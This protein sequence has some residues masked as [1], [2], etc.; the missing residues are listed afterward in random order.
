[1]NAMK[2]PIIGILAN[3]HHY[4][5]GPLPYVDLC[6]LQRDYLYAIERAGGVPMMLPVVEDAATVRQQIAIVD[7]VVLSGGFDVNPAHYGEE[8][9]ALLEEIHP[10]RDAYE[11]MAI[12]I[13]Q[14]LGKPLLGICRGLQILNVAFGG[15]LY[16]DISHAPGERVKHRQKA[17]RFEPTH[18]VDV[19]EGT[20]LRKIVNTSSLATNSFH[21]QAIKQLAPGFVVNAQAKDGVIEG[22]E[23]PGNKFVLAV[24]WHPEMM[25]STDPYAKA[26]FSEF[27]NFVREANDKA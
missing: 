21:H 18:S 27:V 19:M 5:S 14:D 23:L 24:Q 10:E 8:P 25:A 16:Q 11:L 15:T 26:L 7:G 1:M 20:L 13:S 12:K 4:E 22:I 9:T 3:L 6:G 17:Q 2:K